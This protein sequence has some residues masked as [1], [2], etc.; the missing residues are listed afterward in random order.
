MTYI[1]SFHVTSK[2]YALELTRRLETQPSCPSTSS[3]TMWP[4]KVCSEVIIV[5][6]TLI[7]GTD[8]YSTRMLSPL[9]CALLHNL[10]D[11]RTLHARH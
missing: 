7:P 6:P 8:L 4:T 2:T 9:G 11:I 10:Q 3:S 5:F 1:E